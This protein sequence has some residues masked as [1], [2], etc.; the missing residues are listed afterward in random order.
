M[1]SCAAPLGLVLGAE[2]DTEQTA[3][4]TAQ[5]LQWRVVEA[6]R[7]LLGVL[8]ADRPLVLVLDALQWADPSSIDVL[9]ELMDL[10]DEAPILFAYVFTPEPDAPSWQLKEQAAGRSRTATPRLT[11]GRCTERAARELMCSLLSCAETP[12]Q[13]EELVL[14]RTDGNPFFIEEV[15]RALIDNGALRFDGDRWVADRDI[16]EIEIPNTL[17]ATVMA[18]IDRLPAGVR[19]TLQVA[20]IIGREV[21]EQ[22][23]RRVADGGPELDRHLR[24]ALRAGLL[25]EE[26]VIPER[27]YAFT[28]SLIHE[29]AARSL[30]V[31]RRREIHVQVGW[32]LEEIYA[33]NLEAQYGELARHFWEGESWERAF[34]YSRLAAEQ[35]AAAFANDE[36]DRGVH[37]RARIGR[38]VGGRRRAEGGG[39]AGRA[40][41]GHPRADRRVRGG[42]GGLPG[43]H[44]APPGRAE[45]GHDPRGAGRRRRR[46]ARR[47]GDR[48]RAGAQDGPPL[49]LPGPDRRRLD[50][51]WSWRSP[52]CRRT[53]RTSARRGA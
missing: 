32:A 48:R 43:R 53:R 16:A 2:S 17:L 38:A 4:L 5:Q 49:Q 13:V 7:R 45:G 25:R 52:T 27:R 30:L 19:R 34:R 14:A 23:L 36:A 29:A 10:T 33:D 20:A 44:R 18:R 15:L 22:V 24:E 21:S 37:H 9:V 39:D 47:G 28:Q 46:G 35:A 8:L 41:R 31:R 26:A 50:P 1:A 42:A 12:A 40:S 3:G 6:T 51:S 11:L